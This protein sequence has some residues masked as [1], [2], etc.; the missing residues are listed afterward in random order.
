ML[1]FKNKLQLNLERNDEAYIIIYR[2]IRRAND[3]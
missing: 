2:L 3:K 1:Y